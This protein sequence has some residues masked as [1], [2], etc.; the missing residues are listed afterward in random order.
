MSK[1][2]FPKFSQKDKNSASPKIYIRNYYYFD[3]FSKTKVQ[4]K[5]FELYNLKIK[6]NKNKKLTK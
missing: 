4:Q 6:K 3:I 2:L 1:F 5:I